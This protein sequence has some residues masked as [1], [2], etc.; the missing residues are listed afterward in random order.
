MDYIQYLF[1]RERMELLSYH[2]LHSVVC[3]IIII[4]IIFFFMV[5]VNEHYV[6]F[7][8]CCFIHV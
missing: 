3:F 4:I 8:N 6:L 2:V 1:S 5:N 7:F